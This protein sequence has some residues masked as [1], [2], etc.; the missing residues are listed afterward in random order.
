MGN[1]YLRRFINQLFDLLLGR[2]SNSVD[3][4]F[5]NNNVLQEQKKETDQKSVSS[6]LYP[7]PG[8]NRH[9]IA[10]TGV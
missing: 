5:K 6:F 8:S 9:G 4:I 3:C 2:E 1:C 7:E 10:A